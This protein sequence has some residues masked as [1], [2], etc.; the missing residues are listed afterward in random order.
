MDN[1]KQSLELDQL[2]IHSLFNK[3]NNPKS[4][5]DNFFNNKSDNSQIHIN[6]SPKNDKSLS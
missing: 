3:S 1:N 5:M 2:L 6:S 4:T